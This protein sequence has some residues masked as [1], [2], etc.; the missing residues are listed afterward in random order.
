MSSATNVTR[1]GE[2]PVAAASKGDGGATEETSAATKI[3]AKARQKRPADANE[4]HRAMTT[5]LA[6]RESGDDSLT[7]ILGPALVAGALGRKLGDVRTAATI[8]GIVE[9]RVELMSTRKKAKQPV[10]AAPANSAESNSVTECVGASEA[11]LSLS[12][13]DQNV[14]LELPG[15]VPER[16]KEITVCDET[17]KVNGTKTMGEAKTVEPRRISLTSVRKVRDEGPLRDEVGGCSGVREVRDRDDPGAHKN[18]E[19][20]APGVVEI[21]VTAI[22]TTETRSGE[23]ETASAETI[24]RGKTE[25]ERK[26][27]LRDIDVAMAMR[28]HLAT[29][30]PKL[31][32]ATSFLG[33]VCGRPTGRGD[34][35]REVAPLANAVAMEVGATTAPPCLWENRPAR[36]HDCAQVLVRVP[37]AHGEAERAENAQRKILP[38]GIT[39]LPHVKRFRAS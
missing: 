23:L 17:K 29:T 38:I 27:V 8:S 26:R 21:P 19:P 15:E 10:P 28:E 3:C 7:E 25:V 2:K 37:P 36:N 16:D 22:A 4:P 34:K 20:M 6:T 5:E 33:S 9:C 39:T 14:Q 32:T 12:A 11:R 18:V 24:T 13:T 1:R 31:D 35:I 30:N